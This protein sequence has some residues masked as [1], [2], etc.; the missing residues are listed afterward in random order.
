MIL[1]ILLECFDRRLSVRAKVAVYTLGIII[2]MTRVIGQPRKY[3]L[4]ELDVVACIAPL[5]LSRLEPKSSMSTNNSIN[6]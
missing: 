2:R 4:A 5:D 1:V 6:G 3:L